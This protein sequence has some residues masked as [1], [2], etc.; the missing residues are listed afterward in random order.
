[1]SK[2][3]S[4]YLKDKNGVGTE[5]V[6]YD[7][8][9]VIYTE[10]IDNDNRP[11]TL[12]VVFSNGTQYQYEDVNVNHYL[13]FR[14]DASQ[15]KALNRLIKENKYEYKKIEDA[16][17][18]AISEE[19]F[20]R[21]K[22]GFYLENNDEFFEIRNNKEESVFKLSKPLEEG[23]FEMINDILKAVGLETKVVE[24]GKE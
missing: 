15:G 5:K 10:C 16:D 4:V 24:N 3:F 14:E 1:M 18:E 21:S 17:L 23:Y 2:K 11:K 19:L 9:N 8:S 20:F 12:K 7:S 6:W 22:N 13:L